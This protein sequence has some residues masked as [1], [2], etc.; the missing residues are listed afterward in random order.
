MKKAL[1]ALACLSLCVAAGVGIFIATF[2]AD[3][4]RPLAVNKMS[5]TL[6]LPVEMGRLSLVW[7]N[8]LALRVENKQSPFSCRKRA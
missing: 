4:Y 7:K 5:E 3:R 2:N 8:G 6:G 1:I